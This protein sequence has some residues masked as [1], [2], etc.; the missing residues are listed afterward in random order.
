MK[1]DS[2]GNKQ[3]DRDFGGTNSDQLY[4]LQQTNDG[5]YILG[6]WSASGISGDKT[7]AT[8]G[9]EDYWIVKTDSLGIKQWDRDYG[10]FVND[11][12]SSLQQTTDGGYI[13]AGATSSGIG[14]DKTEAIVGGSLSDFWIVKTNSFGVKEWDRD[15]GGT[16]EEYF[17]GNVTQ[18]SDKGFLIDGTSN[19]D[20]SGDKT[21]NNLGSEQTWVLKTDSVGNKQWDKTVRI[22]GQNEKGFAIQTSDGCYAFAN[23]NDAGIGGYKTQTSWGYRDYW[24]VKFC[25]STLAT[26]TE[27]IVKENEQLLISPNPSTGEFTIQN[28]FLKPDHIEIYN[29]M[30]EKMSAVAVD[31]QLLTIDCRLLPSGI[32]FV[33]AFAGEKVLFGKVLKQ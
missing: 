30:G 4:S 20:S 8:W 3:W 21:E 18:T 27:T 12:F 5:G 9:G 14:G 29:L 33:K 10:G 23:S 31:Y 15:Y 16:G 17:F 25:D 11:E 19:S 28:K 26:I 7:Q 22:N 6:G 1:I 24:T 13:L 32:Y 2:S